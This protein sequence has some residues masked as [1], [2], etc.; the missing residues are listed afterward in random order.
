[1]GEARPARYSVPSLGSFR[2]RDERSLE[3]PLELRTAEWLHDVTD[4]AELTSLPVRRI[5]AHAEDRQLPK[6][7]TQAF[8]L[9][10]SRARRRFQQHEMGVLALGQLPLSD[11]SVTEPQDKHLEQRPRCRIGILDQDGRHQGMIDRNRTKPGC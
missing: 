2:R 7:A 4:D 10:H 3:R 11:R 5:D 6:P 9:P 1:V 8:R